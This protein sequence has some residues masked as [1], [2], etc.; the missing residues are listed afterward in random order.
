MK[1]SSL[2]PLALL[3]LI[4]GCSSPPPEQQRVTDAVAAL[5]G[6][7]ELEGLK[8][9]QIEG[10]GTAY[11]L[12]QNLLPDSELPTYK[13]TDYVRIIDLS[14]GRTATRQTRTVQFDFAGNPVSRTHAGLD[15]GVAYNVGADGRAARASC[16]R[17]N[18]NRC[19]SATSCACRASA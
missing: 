11:L 3:T 2:A 6:K 15:S 17:S 18:P 4:L 19:R 12:G 14:A 9:L 1:L 16:G 7:A 13:V 8:T 10:E 5:G